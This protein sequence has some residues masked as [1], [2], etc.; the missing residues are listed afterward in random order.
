MNFRFRKKITLFPGLSVNLSK[1]GIST[2][3]KAG[4]ISWNSRTGKVHANL[5][6]PISYYSKRVGSRDMKKVD[7]FVVAKQHG[8][9]GYSRLNKDELRAL[10]ESYGLV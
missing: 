3:I 8:L 7:M 2:S 4:P 9:K 5:P 10:L 6:G 1:S